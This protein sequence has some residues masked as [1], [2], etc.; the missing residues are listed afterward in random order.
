MFG[1]NNFQWRDLFVSFACVACAEL[2]G[3]C[4]WP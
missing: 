4:L 1:M 2:P 3:N